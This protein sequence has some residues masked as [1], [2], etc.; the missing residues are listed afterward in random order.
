M[1]SFKV[2]TFHINQKSKIFLIAECG[3]NHNGKLSYAYKLIDEAKK[4]GFD[5]VKFQTYIPNLLVHSS[6]HLAIYQKKTKFS[7]QKKMLEKYFLSFENFS[8]LNEYCKKKKI[9]FLSTPFDN[10]S[11]KFLNSIKIPA[12]KISSADLDNFHLL[13]F[14]KEFKKPIILSTGM[15]NQNRIDK[16]LKFLNIKKTNLALMHCVS[17]YP[18]KISNSNLGYLKILKKKKLPIGISDHSNDTIVPYSSSALGIKLIEKHITLSNSMDGPDHI[19]S[20]EV[21]KLKS[22][23]KNIRDIEF[24]LNDNLKKIS[25]EEI[26][27][28][29]AVSRKIFFSKELQKN[30]KI[31]YSDI[32]PLRSGIKN[33]VTINN[34]SKIVNKKVKKDVKKMEVL[35]WQKI[36]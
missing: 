32:I 11:A 5:A 12:F 20:L 3:V 13:K 34:L 14:I 23:V 29:K 4:S 7:N 27:N 36:K 19:A 6:A 30:Q 33:G 31:T 2:G 24:S 16:T 35:T 26:N 10:V 22:F 18:T 25:R 15:S 8:K 17:E 1:K 21:K 28:L 9:I